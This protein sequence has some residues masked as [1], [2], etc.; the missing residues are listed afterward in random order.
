MTSEA[1]STILRTNAQ[2]SH[3]VTGWWRLYTFTAGESR[4]PMDEAISRQLANAGLSRRK[5]PSEVG[6]H[7]DGQQHPP[8]GAK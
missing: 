6:K 8:T 7:A 4:E 3:D 1:P 2:V 5:K